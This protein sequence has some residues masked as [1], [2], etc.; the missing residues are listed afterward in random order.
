ME[1][2]PKITYFDIVVSP[3]ILPVDNEQFILRFEAGFQKFF[4]KS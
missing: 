1:F 4:F 3:F 2:V